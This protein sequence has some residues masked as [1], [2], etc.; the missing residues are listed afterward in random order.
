MGGSGLTF[1]YS[2]VKSA[3]KDHNLIDF[4]K[5]PLLL[6]EQQQPQKKQQL[7]YHVN[8]HDSEQSLI[9]QQENDSVINALQGERRA[10]S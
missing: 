8:T 10:S 1:L 4:S 5:K 3:L 2:S 7:R 6:V 9:I